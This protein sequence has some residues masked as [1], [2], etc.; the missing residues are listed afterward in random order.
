M[1]RELEGKL[2]S[3]FPGKRPLFLTEGGR[4]V[5]AI[6]GGQGECGGTELPE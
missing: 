3:A 2:V 1:V 6:Q 5:G 4:E